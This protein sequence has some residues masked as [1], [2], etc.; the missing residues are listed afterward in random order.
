VNETPLSTEFLLGLL[1]PADGAPVDPEAADAL[2]AAL[3]L[4]IGFTSPDLG[5]ATVALLDR[6]LARAGA[7]PGDDRVALERKIATYLQGAL[8][9]SLIGP[10]RQRLREAL[11]SKDH[12]GL[13]RDFERFLER[14]PTYP[15]TPA[16]APEGSVPGGP[17]GF[18][19]AKKRFEE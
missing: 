14:S 3:I 13:A 15:G 16:P 12:S 7:T 1:R 18:F 17:L 19:L 5:P 4:E 6:V 8:P 9:K 11:W 10:V 2:L